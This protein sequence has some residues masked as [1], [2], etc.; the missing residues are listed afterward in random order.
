[1]SLSSNVMLDYG[2]RLEGRSHVT[3]S[4]EPFG[5]SEASPLHPLPV[6][7]TLCRN[8]LLP[9]TVHGQGSSRYIAVKYCSMFIYSRIGRHVMGGHQ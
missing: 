8:I 9:G 7:T 5:Q 3:E 2:C 6:V 1:M 4:I